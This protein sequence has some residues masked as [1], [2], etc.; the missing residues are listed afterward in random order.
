MLPDEFNHRNK[1]DEK[2]LIAL[3]E[4]DEYEPETPTQ[5]RIRLVHE[6]KQKFNKNLKSF[7][8]GK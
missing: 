4:R 1:L 3:M 6:R 5:K 2:Y 8:G 7:I